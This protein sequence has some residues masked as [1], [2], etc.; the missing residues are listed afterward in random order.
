MF[1]RHLPVPHPL[2]Q[3]VEQIDQQAMKQPLNHPTH[4]PQKQHMHLKQQQKQVSAKFCSP[5]SLSAYRK[6]RRKQL[7]TMAH[8]DDLE[9]PCNI[10][11]ANE[12]EHSLV[13]AN[14]TECATDLQPMVDQ[15]IATESEPQEMNPSKGKK[16][17]HRGPTK[18]VRAHARSMEERP[19][20][21]LNS[22]GQ[23]VGPTDKVVKEYTRFL[24]TLARNPEFAPLT[25]CD[26]PSLP[27]H[28]KMWNYIQEKYL[29]PT[30]GRKWAMQTMDDQWRAYKSRMKSEH[31]YAYKTDA[32][33]LKSCPQTM[34]ENQFRAFINYW[35]SEPVKEESERNKANRQLLEDMHTMGPTS[36][37]MLRQNLKEKDPNKEEPSKAKVYRESRKRKPGKSYKTSYEKT[38]QNIYIGTNGR[39]GGSRM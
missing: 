5:G 28:D 36:Y 29:V 18:L 34:P 3:Q 9:S 31:Y 23:P 6:L 10:H 19:M 15:N 24:G 25:Y 32:E 33:R 7:Q 13:N 2:Q 11:L 35:D 22:F 20:V 21:I 16:R 17:K 37:A 38:R 27:T 1:R 14:E 39:N 8:D 30:E 12:G 26:W 4:D